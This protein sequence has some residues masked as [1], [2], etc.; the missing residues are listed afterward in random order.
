VRLAA[1][2]AMEL[3]TAD[4]GTLPTPAAK[5]AALS[6]VWQPE[7]AWIDAIRAAIETP[8]SGERREGEK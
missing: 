4:G 7:P 2:L 3:E 6:A 5:H 8:D 1:S